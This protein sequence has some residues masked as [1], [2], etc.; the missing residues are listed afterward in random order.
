MALINIMK[1][2]RFRSLL[3]V[4]LAMLALG[5]A[6][7]TVQAIDNIDQLN[8]A[9]DQETTPAPQD[10]YL[11][12]GFLKLIGVLIVIIAIVWLLVR[13]FGR[14]IRARMQGSWLRVLDEVSLGQNRGVVLCEINGKIYAL[15]VTD[16]QINCLF[17]LDDPE[18]LADIELASMQAA[19]EQKLA[20]PAWLARVNQWLDRLG[21]QSRRR[22]PVPR[23]FHRL[24]QEQS[25]RMKDIYEQEVHNE[26]NTDDRRNRP[27]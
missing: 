21:G 12:V 7:G 26:R 14:Q 15:G 16:H 10:N 5:C 18:L 19:E 9:M 17:E 8:T 1:S 25:Q 6:V 27:R 22:A 2:W 11:L 3:I 24:V 13:M 4:V 23:N 20:E